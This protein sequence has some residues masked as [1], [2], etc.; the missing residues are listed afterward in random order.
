MT[1]T[2]TDLKEFTD[3]VKKT[4]ERGLIKAPVHLSL[5]NE[6]A[7]IHIFE[8]IKPT[9][10]VFST[11][12]S[13]YHALLK[14]VGQDW[15][16]NEIRAGRSIHINNR[17]HKFFSSAI[18]A[19]CCPIAVGVALA[20]KLKGKDDT[21]WCFVGDMAEQTGIFFESMKYG[22]CNDLPLHFI[23]EDNG[24]SVNT[25]TQEAWGLHRYNTYNNVSIYFY[26]RELPHQGSGVFVLF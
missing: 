6:N 10:W 14:G 5:G 4:F 13:H 24:V 17:K 12:R 3:L 16:F 11:H 9:D 20:L 23:V 8:R 18:V 1:L 15:L 7:L 26:K 19:G 22:S 2:E 21:V 25:P